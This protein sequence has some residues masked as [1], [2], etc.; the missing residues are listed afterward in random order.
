MFCNADSQAALKAI[1]DLSKPLEFEP[2][3]WGVLNFFIGRLK[4]RKGKNFALYFFVYAKNLSL[5]EK[6]WA[7]KFAYKK[8]LFWHLEKSVCLILLKIIFT[9]PNKRSLH[10]YSVVSGLF[11]LQFFL[12]GN[13]FYFWAIFYNFKCVDSGPIFYFFALKHHRTISEGI[14]GWKI[15]I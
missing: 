2:Q 13:F 10:M 12:Y 5:F 7:L 4:R 8:H 3:H 15:Y 6:K 1:F 14:I 9:P 11:I